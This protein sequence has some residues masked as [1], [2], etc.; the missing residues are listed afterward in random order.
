MP[1]YVGDRLYPNYPIIDFDA[2]PEQIETM[3][4]DSLTMSNLYLAGLGGD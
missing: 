3:F 4:Q 2:S 1:V